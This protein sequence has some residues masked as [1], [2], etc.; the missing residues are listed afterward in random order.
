MNDGQVNSSSQNPLP[1]FSII[2]IYLV[3]VVVIVAVAFLMN[4]VQ[5]VAAFSV[6]LIKM[7]AHAAHSVKTTNIFA[8]LLLDFIITTKGKAKVVL[9]EFELDLL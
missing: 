3:R 8:I 1:F 2:I 6:V 5:K 7:Y 4:F 9:A